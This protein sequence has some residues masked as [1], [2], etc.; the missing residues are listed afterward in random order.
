[1]HADGLP[2]TKSNVCCADAVQAGRLHRRGHAPGLLLAVAQQG[3]RRGLPAVSSV[4]SCPQ[5]QAHTY[6]VNSLCRRH[7]DTGLSTQLFSTTCNRPEA[8]VLW[9][10]HIASANTVSE[11]LIWCRWAVLVNPLLTKPPTNGDFCTAWILQGPFDLSTWLN[12]YMFYQGSQGVRN[13]FLDLWE[14]LAGN[15]SYTANPPWQK[16]QR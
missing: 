14:Y 11:G 4:L 12:W 16:I 5:S 7:L 2:V 1:M 8:H 10:L 9:I 3:L 13:S 6:P 15:I